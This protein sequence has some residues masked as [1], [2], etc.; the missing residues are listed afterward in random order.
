MSAN[1][2]YTTRQELEE[3]RKQLLTEARMSYEELATRAEE[4]T[5]D[6]RQR[7]IWDTIEGIDFLLEEG[8]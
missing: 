8:S 1:V 7:S 3:H 2:I 6:R 4:W 5:L